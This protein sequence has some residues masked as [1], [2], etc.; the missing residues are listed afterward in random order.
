[1]KRLL[2]ILGLLA[3]WTVAGAQSKIVADSVQ[4]QI[5]GA[6]SKYN[7]Y[8]PDGYN[9]AEQYPV[10]YLLH[11]LYGVYSDWQD[12]GRMKDVADLLIASGELRPVVIVM[13]NAGHPDVHHVQNGYFNVQDW[14]YEDFFFQEFLPEVESKYHCGGSKGT[15]AIMGLSMGGGGTVVYAQRHPDLFSSAYAM[16]AWLDNRQND[17]R[18]E[19]PETDKL[20]ITAQSVCDHSA[21]GFLDKADDNT[22]NALRTVKWYVDC[23]D[24]DFI[25]DLSIQFYRKMREKKVPC[26]LRVR[27][28]AHTWEYWHTALYQSLPFASRNFCN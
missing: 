11:G 23:G 9:P 4:S 28:G 1:M 18:S 8:L 6:E 26:E 7:V 20:A 3:A 5:L 27:D 19:G 15:R 17:V 25:F 21:V 12:R 10:I 14:P 16:S 13:P 22:L 2:L 24:D